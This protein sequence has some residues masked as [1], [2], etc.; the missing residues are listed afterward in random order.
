MAQITKH[1][2]RHGDRKVAV[3]FREVPGE[4]HMCLVAYTQVLNR[5]V[6]DA[7]MECIN[8]ESGQQSENLA[9]ALN[10]VYTRDG[11][12]VLQQLHNEGQLKKVQT[13]A[14]TMTP[15]PSAK[16][17]IKLSDLN[18]L[19]NKI[20]GG[21][22]AAKEM[23]E[24]DASMGLQDP[25]DVARRKRD[26][27]AKATAPQPTQPAPQADYVVPPIKNRT[28]R[29][30]DMSDAAIAYRLHQQ[31]AKMAA[32]A[33]G[34]LAESQRMLTEAAQLDPTL[35]PQPAAA[36]VAESASVK[37]T[38]PRVKKAAPEPVAVVEA[39][40]PA[41]RGRPAKARATVA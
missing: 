5:H 39:P 26:A 34:L 40:Q 9:D 6:H 25:Q 22:E 30:D 36:P 2:G 33:R 35:A 10:R 37:V 29:S 27:K 3:I 31:A 7:L 32:E 8:S 38:K 41:K 1:V 13:E 23:A 24:M 16:T 19:I 17:D 21:G 14:I 20:K 18:E 15:T 11:K 28:Y 12:I 4:S